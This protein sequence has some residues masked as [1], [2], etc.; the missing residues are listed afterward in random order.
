MKNFIRLI[1]GS[2]VV[3]TVFGLSSCEKNNI[4]GTSTGTAEFAIS[5]PADAVTKSATS[6]DSGIVSYQIMISVT[7]LQGNAVLT[8]KLIP[9]Y[10]FGTD[11][12]SENVEIKTGEF[13]L[14]K[15]MIINSSGAVL[16][17]APV[18]G[19]PL[20]YLSSKPL[21]FTFNIMP[22]QVTRI[23]PEVLAVCDQTPEKFGYATFGVQIIKPLEFWTVCILDNPLIMAPVQFTTA[24]LTVGTPAG[25]KFPFK[26]EAAANHLVIRGG[27]DIYYFVLEKEGF[28]AQ[29]IQ[30]AA[31]DLL[32][33]TKENP[34]VLKI[35]VGN[36]VPQILFFQPGPDAG[37]D[38]MV[39]NL[40]P[41]KNFGGHKYFEATYMSE[42]LL[43]VMRSNKSLI[44]FDLSQ[45]PKPSTI[46]KVILKLSY[47]L[48]VP[49]DSTIFF[50]NSGTA[51]NLKPAGVLQQIIEPWEE[52]QVTWNKLPKTTELNQVL[53]PPFIRNVNFIEVDVT[54]LFVSPSANP[55]PYHG[56]L[57]RL[58]QNEKFKGFRFASSDFPEP[59]MRPRLSVH[60]TPGK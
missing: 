7:D 16:Y 57:F 32:A 27:S 45:L 13:R 30:V 37:K 6:P 40:E 59:S 9:L 41:D 56:I 46:R 8:D 25:W 44:W 39:S 5:I 38:A 33:T 43:T 49:W 14:T 11:Y 28:P 2:L 24:T 23:L 15:F 1:L 58:N 20:A 50:S 47:D 29:K 34:F 55:L 17:A 3:L 48:P 19:S 22:K 51:Y 53:I 36:Q 60:F 18:A 31:K 52:N 4:S 35:P 54:N 12:V 42:P 26:L 21:P 10:T